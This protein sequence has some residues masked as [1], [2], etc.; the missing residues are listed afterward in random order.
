MR[1]GEHKNGGAPPTLYLMNR[2]G[3]EHKALTDGKYVAF[4]GRLSPDGKKLVFISHKYGMGRQELHV[5]S[6]VDKQD[7]VLAA[8]DNYRYYPR[9]SPDST[10][11]AYSR[12]H[13]ID[14]QTSNEVTPPLGTTKAGPVVMLD[15]RRGEEQLITSQGQWLDYM[16]DW[17][18]DGEWILASSNRASPPT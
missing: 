2:D 10:R 18:P 13:S 9:W 7:N 5:K 15:I 8:D 14:Q 17:S 4:G 16:Y 12:F 6:L 1:D 11:I 3:T